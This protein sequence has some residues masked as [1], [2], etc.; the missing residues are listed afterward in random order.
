MALA[1]T[2]GAT[3]AT[4]PWPLQG[5]PWP[6]GNHGNLLIPYHFR[7]LGDSGFSLSFRGLTGAW[8]PLASLPPLAPGL[9]PLASPG[10]TLAPGPWPPS[11]PW[12]PSPGQANPLESLGFTH[13]RE[14]KY[15]ATPE[16]PAL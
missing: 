5:P 15:L 13:T 10:L 9:P 8:P 14:F 12:P 7:G 4:G 6:H 1:P 2:S 11:L 3:M 16:L